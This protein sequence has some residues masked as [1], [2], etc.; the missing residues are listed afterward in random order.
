MCYEI[1]ELRSKKSFHNKVIFVITLIFDAPI[2]AQTL[3]RG[4]GRKNN[5]EVSVKAA[6]LLHSVSIISTNRTN[7]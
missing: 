7:V 1:S 4:T 2:K 6:V 3:P 5:F